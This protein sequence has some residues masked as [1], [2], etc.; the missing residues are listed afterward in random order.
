MTR[1]FLDSGVLLTGWK[2][3]E[4]DRAQAIRVMEDTQRKFVS[5]Q[6]IRL[7]LLPKPTFFKNKDEL[8]FYDSHFS[9]LKGEAMLTESLG[10]EALA[11][12][13]RYGLAAAD[14]LNVAAAIRLEA[15][16]FVTTEV[17]GKPL[18]RVVELTVL[19]LFQA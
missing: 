5:S 1:T 8:A 14:A 6:I 18:F 2:G 9:D 16:E 11:L 3:K 19:N 17:P 10:N 4:D 13:K 12:G 15:D 7:E